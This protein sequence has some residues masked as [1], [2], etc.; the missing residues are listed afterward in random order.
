MKKK[1]ERNTK[2]FAE[3][4]KSGFKNLELSRKGEIRTATD[5]PSIVCQSDLSDIIK[6]ST[7]RYVDK[8]VLFHNF[9]SKKCSNKKNIDWNYTI[10]STFL[11]LWEQHPD[12]K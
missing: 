9:V 3:I 4:L 7:C 8:I 5:G 10:P 2:I 11:N 12:L 6:L 1:R